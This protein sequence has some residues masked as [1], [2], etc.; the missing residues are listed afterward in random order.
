MKTNINIA[1]L[2][3]AF[4]AQEHERVTREK[5]KEK[6]FI[7]KCDAI[8]GRCLT[9]AYDLLP[10]LT[11]VIQMLPA[12]SEVRVEADRKRYFSQVMLRFDFLLMQAGAFKAYT[13]GLIERVVAVYH[14]STNDII[15]YN[16]GAGDV[17]VRVDRHHPMTGGVYTENPA[18]I[19]VKLA[20]WA[21]ICRAEIQS[22]V[23]EA[24]TGQ[25]ECGN[26][27]TRRF[28]HLADIKEAAKASYV[29]CDECFSATWA[30]EN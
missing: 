9:A 19:L 8:F 24:S 7:A 30:G 27:G 25:C 13:P 28:P 18:D 23:D 3:D 16:F 5:E 6:E 21:G 17:G 26:P 12:A 22:Q 2:V 4:R 1:E 14:D 10:T 11:E 15:K 29:A 20:E